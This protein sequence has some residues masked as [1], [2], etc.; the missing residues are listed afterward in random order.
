MTIKNL[1]KAPFPW[2]GGKTRRHADTWRTIRAGDLIVPI[3]KGQG[4]KRG[5]RQ[6]PLIDGRLIVTS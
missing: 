1:D 6:E 5:E 3:R 4:L 2:F